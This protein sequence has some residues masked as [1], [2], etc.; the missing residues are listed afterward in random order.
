MGLGTGVGLGTGGFGA[1]PG[2]AG[3]PGEGAGTLGE[4]DAA[5]ERLA[6]D[7]K[8]R[9]ARPRRQRRPRRRR[10]RRRRRGPRRRDAAGRRRPGQGD[11]VGGELRLQV[12]GRGR[13]RQHLEGDDRRQGG[14]MAAGASACGHAQGRARRRQRPG[15]AQRLPG[16]RVAGQRPRHL[17]EIAFGVG[18]QDLH[19]DHGQ[20]GAAGGHPRCRVDDLQLASALRQ[21]Q[22]GHRR[23]APAAPPVPRAA[24]GQRGQQGQQSTPGGART[25]RRSS[26][27]EAAQSWSL[28]RAS[29]GVPRP[30]RS[31]PPE[32][33]RAALE[34][35]FLEDGLQHRG[36]RRA[37]MFSV[38]SLTSI[39]SR[40]SAPLSVKTR[41]TPSVPSRAW[42][43]PR[44][45]FWA[46]S[47]PAH[48]SSA[49]AA[50]APRG[51]KAAL[52]DEVRGLLTWRRPRREQ[53]VVRVDEAVLGETVVPS[54][55][56]TGPLHALARDVR[57]VAPSR[58]ATLSISSMKRM[59]DCCTRSTAMRATTRRRPAGS[60][61]PA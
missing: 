26:K 36:Q 50:P 7:W 42:Y 9:R 35:H 46:R 16:R 38:A 54:T 24:R 12:R 44:S 34:G 61:P 17:R 59:P 28:T 45:A 25:P 41:S 57:P 31:S 4:G 40:I 11:A 37:P 30:L 5:P 39:G 8:R 29:C 15:L 23:R 1:G 52:R 18:A 55:M 51:W 33:R 14:D 3:P 2:D 58:P 19:L 49:S 20:A 48:E 6:R 56:G 32:A 47:G 27:N 10:G 53:D 22:A 60:L 13:R 21:R 43:W